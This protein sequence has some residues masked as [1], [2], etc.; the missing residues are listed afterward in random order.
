M[1]T[2]KRY[3]KIILVLSDVHWLVPFGRN[4]QF[5]GRES[6]LEKLLTKLHPQKYED[7]CQRVALAGLGGV[8]KT[9]IALE[10]AY[11]VQ[12]NHPHQSVF[13]VP[14]VDTTSFERAYRQ[15]G[16]KLRIAGIDDDKA[17]VKSLVKL[18]LSQDS[19][20]SWL[21]IIDNADDID[22]LYNR[23]SKGNEGNEPLALVDYLP[24]SRK[25]SILFTTRNHKVAVKHAGVNVIKVTEMAEGDSLQLLR[26]SLID[27]NL[28]GEES[29][30]TKL[31][32]L[33]TQ[34]PLAIKQAAAFMNEN[35]TPIS[36]YLG[37]YEANPEE[38]PELLS[39]DFEDQ[40]RYRETQ[41]PIATTWLISFRQILDR[42][43][44]AA[45]YLYFM[46]CIAQQDVP[47]SLLPRKSRLKESQAIGTLQAYAFIT[48]HKD[49]HSYYMHRLVRIVVQKW[50][51][52][53]GKLREAS[54]ETLKHIA[55]VF[56]DPEHENRD[57]WTAYLPHA[58]CVLSYQ[59]YSDNGEESQRNLL[60]Q[61]GKCFHG[62]ESQRNLL[63]QVGKC[64]HTIGKFAEA[65]Q[66][67][68]Q[69][70]Q[71]RMKVSR[72]TRT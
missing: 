43:P 51:E 53:E 7:D 34:L 32:D 63:Y 67:H 8:G 49:R 4:K 39:A 3:A 47:H 50:L 1:R 41:N 14:A 68:Q 20:G 54:E 17:N 18:A 57:V 64:F 72:V 23:N 25:G 37:I 16:Q 45:E 38:L 35:G 36:E 22:M 40:G 33:L 69:A 28:E 48:P 15:I 19:A 30:A 71:L 31:L 44:L 61:V 9:Q 70:L 5:V 42:D 66:I 10:A 60:Y 58:Q 46:S 65:E 62:E 24:F 6:H 12:E 56:P 59:D 2:L 29:N 52:V 11:R 21:L 13:W 27:T 55:S 26:A